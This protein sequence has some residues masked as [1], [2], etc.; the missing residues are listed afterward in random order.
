MTGKKPAIWYSR[1]IQAITGLGIAWFISLL[2]QGLGRAYLFSRYADN[3]IYSQ[4]LYDVWLMFLRGSLFD[5]RI[6]S[7]AF[8]SFIPIVALL[9]LSTSAFKLW[10]RLS[11]WINT[12]LTAAIA[13]LTITNIFY[14]ATYQRNI[15]IFIFGLI[16]DDTVAI[17]QTLWNDYPVISG[18]IA[19]VIFVMAI[20]WFFR[21]LR[22]I[23]AAKIALTT[24]WPT[25]TLIAALLFIGTF[26][27]MR[28]SI[29]TFPLRRS[30]VQIS[31]IN[32]LNTLVP[33]GI[34][35]LD[36]AY[37]DYKESD[38]F[39]AATDAE[40]A[41]LLSQ[42][43][44]KPVA[45]SLN[46]FAAKT[47]NHP[48]AKNKPPHVILSVMESMG[49][50][51]LSLDSADRD[52]LGQLRPHW[53]ND[54]RF[55]R[56]IA[57]GDGTIDTLSRLF[58]RSPYP[59]I[60]QSMAQSVDFTSNMLKPYLENGYKV[61]YVYSGNGAWRN[62]NQFLPSLGVSEF[63]EQSK[64]ESL[65][66]EATISTWGLPD[67]YMFDYLQ[68]RLL[69]A[70][71]NNEHLLIIT[72]STT[73]H[74]PYKTPLHYR[75]TPMSVSA[76]E[77]Q[78]LANL[79]TGNKLIEVL[80]TLRYS[81]DTLGE[82]IGWVKSQ[83]LGQHTIIAVTGDHNVRGI[84]YPDPSEQVL[85]HAVPF[86][87]YVPEA[88]QQ[89]RTF[90]P[91]RVGSHK[92]IWPTLYELSLSD[93]PYYRTGCDLLAAE[94]DPQWCFGYNRDLLLTQQGAYFFDNKGG[95]RPWA[96]GF[97]LAPV[98]PRTPEQEKYF[99]E[100]QTLTPLLKWQLSRQVNGQP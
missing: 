84:G 22:N 89:G 61:I 43:F 81:N 6:A 67:E 49:E 8:G 32:L 98:Q 50:H 60:S 44:A 23:C 78:R 96:N 10:L 91:T 85:G 47:G 54:W 24:R 26:V 30:D 33:N 35:G 41:M 68:Q 64:L 59:N 17:L 20:F 95:F 80:H 56:F 48:L 58:V 40:G 57:E 15:D 82:F 94:Q 45:P 87:L 39:S 72:M 97:L 38:E 11:P 63:V 69:L 2:I 51:L 90:D 27:G 86:Y 46:A 37:K 92:D 83:P 74:P 12:L 1:F 5:I 18:L 21:W 36:W 73:N 25:A 9:A 71:Q 79:A 3:D 62:L 31:E 55:N 14:Y 76:Q 100:K 77:E 4:H 65:Y 19:M 66:P 93:T 53:Q 13:W 42:F 34:I 75:P 7:I 70:E 29:D 28:G 16:D 88:Y 99:A 52:L